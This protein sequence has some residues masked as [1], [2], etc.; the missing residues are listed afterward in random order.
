LVLI[1][2]RAIGADDVECTRYVAA[3][4]KIV[5]VPCDDGR[6]PDAGPSA[7]GQ[8]MHFTPAELDRVGPLRGQL[9]MLTDA[10]KAA[11]GDAAFR[12]SYCTALAM[13]SLVGRTRSR[14]EKKRLFDETLV[15][16]AKLGERGRLLTAALSKQVTDALLDAPVNKA[17]GSRLRHTAE[18]VAFIKVRDR[19]Q[20]GCSCL[21]E[22]RP[23][24]RVVCCD[25]CGLRDL[26]ARMQVDP[27]G[28]R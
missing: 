28:R 9:T 12:D 2:G 10:F 24:R 22:G 17:S 18:G 23:P 26:G 19:F 3:V 7:P 14:K 15:M 20:M 25:N 27:A 1:A 11:E 16:Q 8:T 6:P 5:R 21:N 13:A 4:G